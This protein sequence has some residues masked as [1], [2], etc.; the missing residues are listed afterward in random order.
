LH[1]PSLNFLDHPFAD[2]HIK[3]LNVPVEFA[4]NDREQLSGPTAE[5]VRHAIAQIPN[6]WKPQ[7]LQAADQAQPS[8]AENVPDVDD[9]WFK[10]FDRCREY[11]NIMG[12]YISCLC[13]P[14]IL[15]GASI[16]FDS[17]EIEHIRQLEPPCHVWHRWTWSAWSGGKHLHRVAPL[18]QPVY[19]LIAAELITTNE[20][21]RIQVC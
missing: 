9:V 16:A 1:S 5:N 10:F 14:A 18:Q 6:P 20:I 3:S 15:D 13:I 2:G 7:I 11:V 8:Q 17:I 21:G 12:T 4:C 19:H